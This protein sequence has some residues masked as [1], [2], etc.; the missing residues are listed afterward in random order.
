MLLSSGVFPGNFSLNL[1]DSEF[2]MSPFGSS[3]QNYHKLQDVFELSLFFIK[4]YIG[5]TAS[6]SL[7]LCIC[8]L[9]ILLM[10]SLNGG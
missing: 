1:T 6:I 3:L 5:I 4:L 9:F 10:H 7:A 8:T 2:L